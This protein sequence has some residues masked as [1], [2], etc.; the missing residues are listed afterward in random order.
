MGPTG[1]PLLGSRPHPPCRIV[2]I[3]FMGAGKSTVGPVLA[4]LAGCPFIDLD[5]V[6]EHA[7][8]RSVA[9]IFR[10]EGEAGF[11]VR[12][13]AALEKALG[14]GAG[15]L[16]LAVGGGTVLDADNRALIIRRAWPVWLRVS[17]EEVGRRLGGEDPSR[18]LFG[19]GAYQLFRQRQV[20]Y[21]AAAAYTV[22][23]DRR[24]PEAVAEE[25]L[26]R[27]RRRPPLEE[28]D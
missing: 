1:T 12:E 5:R 8:G 27:W 20:V 22:D 15:S 9:D 4:R 18:P 19:P 28:D 21:A 25:I 3:G 13:R 24:P 14:P 16:I 2:L 17:W 10:R 7:V 26:A 11:R 23:V 6:I